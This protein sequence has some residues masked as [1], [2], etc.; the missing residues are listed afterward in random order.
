MNDESPDWPL[1]LEES[2][3]PEEVLNIVLHEYKRDIDQIRGYAQLI[4]AGSI[5]SHK[6][7]E[8]IKYAAEQ[9]NVLRDAIM[10]YLQRRRDSQNQEQ[11]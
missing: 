11:T 10:D 9:M 5:D 7:T 3:N 2:R 4:L 1:L 8:R 6:A